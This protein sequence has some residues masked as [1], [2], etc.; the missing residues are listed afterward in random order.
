MCKILWIS[1]I[2][3]R[4]QKQVNGSHWGKKALHGRFSVFFWLLKRYADMVQQQQA[5]ET[6]GIVPPLLYYFFVY[7]KY[8]TCE[9]FAENNMRNKPGRR[10][11]F[12]L[13]APCSL[14]PFSFLKTSEGTLQKQ[15]L[16]GPTMSLPC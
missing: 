6:A 8:I 16:F 13:N 1:S 12:L 5:R 3:K 9:I 15:C 11:S 10:P 14:V 7:S 2:D 4:R